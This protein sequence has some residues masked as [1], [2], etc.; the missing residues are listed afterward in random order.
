MDV[1]EGG[2]CTACRQGERK[3]GRR[4]AALAGWCPPSARTA[5][6]CGKLAP[7]HL[8]GRGV[9]LPRL[10]VHKPASMKRRGDGQPAV[11]QAS[12]KP[13]ASADQPTE[14][15]SRQQQQ[16]LPT[17]LREAVTWLAAPS[18]WNLR[19]MPYL[20]GGCQEEGAVGR[21]QL[22]AAAAAAA[23][24][25]VE[26]PLLMLLTRQTCAP[27]PTAPRARCGRRCR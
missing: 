14:P 7:P 13:A 18:S 19:S 20:Q 22:L 27:S 12:S 10:A 1:Q 4:A 24:A 26:S 23:T 15:A 5:R 8:S 3:A 6:T 17:C 25:E 11:Q 21:G 2:V 16:Q 9:R